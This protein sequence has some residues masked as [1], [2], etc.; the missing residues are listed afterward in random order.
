VRQ[1]PFIDT[2]RESNDHRAREWQECGRSTARRLSPRS[3]RK[4]G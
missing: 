2:M 4:Q 3:L 1:S